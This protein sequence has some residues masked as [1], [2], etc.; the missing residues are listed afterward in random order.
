[1]TN[2][3]C[4]MTNYQLTFNNSLLI[5]DKKLYIHMKDRCNLSTKIL[6]YSVNIRAKSKLRTEHS[7]SSNKVK[8]TVRT[9]KTISP[10]RF[11][12]IKFRN[13]VF[14][15]YRNF[16]AQLKKEDYPD[17]E[18]V[19]VSSLDYPLLKYLDKF[20]LIS[21]I[22]L[23]LIILLTQISALDGLKIS[24]LTPADLLPAIISLTIL[25][26]INLSKKIKENYS[27]IM[28]IFFGLLIFNTEEMKAQNLKMV[29]VKVKDQYDSVNVVNAF[30]RVGLSSGY[31]DSSGAVTFL[32]NSVRDI[33]PDGFEIK[34]N[35]PNPFEQN[36]RIEF[37]TDRARELKI[38][39]IN[40][41][42]EEISSRTER[43]ISG[44]YNIE[45]DG[46]GVSNQPLILII[47]GEGI[48]VVRKM[49]KIGSSVKGSQGIR[50][51]SMGGINTEVIRKAKGELDLVIEKAHYWTLTEIINIENDTT[52]V[53]Y[54]NPKMKNVQLTIQNTCN[55]STEL[56][57][58]AIING[59][60]IEAPTGTINTQVK[61]ADEYTIKAGTYKKDGITPYSF[62]RTITKTNIEEIID[63]IRVV[64]WYLRNKQG[65]IV[66]SMYV[67]GIS[68]ISDTTK[69]NPT[70]YKGL[71]DYLHFSNAANTR[72]SGGFYFPQV[73]NG[74]IPE[75]R[76]PPKIVIARKAYYQNTN[77]S[78]NFNQIT[79]D[80]IVNDIN[81]WVK[82]LIGQKNIPIEIVD[83]VD[84]HK[85]MTTGVHKVIVMPNGSMSLIGTASTIGA[86]PATIIFSQ[87][88]L[89]SQDVFLLNPYH[90]VIQVSRLQELYTTI[91]SLNGNVWDPILT[92]GESVLYDGVH[93]V[94]PTYPT[95][96]DYKI[97]KTA[98]EQ[99]YKRGEHINT[100][101][102]L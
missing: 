5:F 52:I 96:L 13:Q 41:L 2:D 88:K 32:V 86:L 3:K 40:I 74:F 29:T 99:T 101:L 75:D 54:I 60:R 100:I 18:P 17:V 24:M 15:A 50:I 64:D 1:M 97:V 37:Q 12:E 47:S 28:I 10:E 95:P 59:K 79:I 30:V 80:A 19:V 53:R 51:V 98:T 87:T 44:R 85:E 68:P 14:D 63:T 102:E 22:M 92:Q 42:G 8:R 69:M 49:M 70:R 25:S 6:T 27:A 31:T 33:L 45:I 39:I 78:H 90:P 9:R 84:V 71:L 93:M 4:P 82:P 89:N 62:K 36:T 34:D 66:D 26:M 83:S 67:Q 58:Y 20:S 38:K 48:N 46:L 73:I 56:P 7:E 77:T 21:G 81:E 43:V 23:F 35:Y 76:L 11:R 72:P 61:Q 16:S 65:Q 94:N 91:F 55:D 57:A